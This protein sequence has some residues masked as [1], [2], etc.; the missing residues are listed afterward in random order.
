VTTAQA[1]AR[2]FCPQKTALC[3]GFS[4]LGL[5]LARETITIQRLEIR[6]F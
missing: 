3:A 4:L 1:T 5:P 2:I 6:P